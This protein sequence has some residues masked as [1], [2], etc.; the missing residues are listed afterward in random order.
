M[1]L[2]GRFT[3]L[4][5]LP[6]DHMLP[7]YARAWGPRETSRDVWRRHGALDYLNRPTLPLFLTIN[8]AEDP[9]ALHQ[10]TALRKRLAE[11]GSEAVFML[12]REPR[13]HKVPLAPEILGA[14]NDYLKQ[15][16]H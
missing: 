16:L 5:L 11:L 4:D 7:R 8:V 14:M 6:D 3:Y 1:I 9:D 15:R 2:S 13:G 12:D 10:M